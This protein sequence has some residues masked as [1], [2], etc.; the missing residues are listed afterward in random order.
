[1]ERVCVCVCVCAH[2][3]QSP[4]PGLVP[5]EP[6]DPVGSAHLVPVIWAPAVPLGWSVLWSARLPAV[7]ARPRA[8]PY[9]LF[10]GRSDCPSATTAPRIL[11]S[12]ASSAPGHH[13]PSF[14]NPPLLSPLHRR[15][16]SHYKVLYQVRQG[17]RA[18]SS[19]GGLPGTQERWPFVFVIKDWP[20]GVKTAPN[21]VPVVGDDDGS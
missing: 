4:S 11:P 16:S 20:F 19:V 2:E 1:M 15:C 7:Q 21:P 6:G 5:E 8:L 14:E 3:R 10:P 9:D 17:S 13:A 12:P 18:A